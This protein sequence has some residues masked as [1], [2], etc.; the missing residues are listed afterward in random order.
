MWVPRS[1]CPEPSDAALVR[2][3][4]AGRRT[5]F[6][7]L[8]ERYQRRAV[9][10]ACRLLGD[11]HDALEV[12]QEAFVRAYLNLD[13]L[14][15]A[16]RFGS[17]LLRIVTNLALNFR[18][19]RAATGPRLGLEDCL[20]TGRE[21]AP[22]D[23]DRSRGPGSE[24]AAAELRGIVQQA[25]AALPEQQRTALVLFALEQLPQKQVAEIMACSVEAVKW[26]VFQARRKLREQLA[27][28]L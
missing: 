5:A 21:P 20:L 3:T 26:H 2:Q 7:L 18:R 6:D 28:Y 27:D 16:E 19:D 25:I 1:T 17:W 8:V 12:C 13:T 23:R 14:E 9:S 22:A 11:L 10:I 15:S 24:L 4:L